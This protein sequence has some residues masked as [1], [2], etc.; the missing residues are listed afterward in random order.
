VFGRRNV[1]IPVMG[2]LVPDFHRG[3]MENAPSS[4]ENG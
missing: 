3:P 2:E 1:Y 4:A